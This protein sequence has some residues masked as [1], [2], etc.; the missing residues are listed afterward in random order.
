MLSGVAAI[1]ELLSET[2]ADLQPDAAPAHLAVKLFEGFDRIERL[3]ATAKTLLARRVEESQVWRRSG[4]ATAAEYVA[5]T[6]GSSV[7]AARD[8]LA[9]SAHVS[10]LPVVEEA[11]RAGNLSTAQATVVADAA[12][13]APQTQDQLVDEAQRSSLKELR[14]SCLSVKAAADA[15]REATHRRIHQNR[16]LRTFTDREG[17]WNLVA[18]GPAEAGARIEAALRPLIEERFTQARDEGRHE[19][20]EA[21][22][23]DALATAVDRE[24]ADTPSSKPKL[25]FL[26]L[27]RVDLEALRRGE[28]GDGEL[29]EL[30]GIGPI[31]VTVAR[32]LLGE[33]IL[34]LV[35]TKGVDVLHVTHLGRGPSAAQKVALLWQQPTCVVEGCCR[36]RVES[37]HTHG[38]EYVK[39]GH[40]RLDE[41]EPLCPDHHDLKTYRGWALIDGTGKRPL[42]PPDDPR[43]PR[44]KPPPQQE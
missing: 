3:A 37:D 18:R 10:G 16:Y 27:L 33:S 26:G 24:R 43:H 8:V 2:V 19:A 42:V 9:T 23:F 36:T 39:T 30:T 28:P 11:M 17:G 4:Y 14:D 12:S 22:A 21:Y 25:Q 35:I 6:T 20:R 29:C 41:L 44:N 5:A 40:T 7:Q 13:T 15:D 34:K 38:F 32:E 31:P 1:E